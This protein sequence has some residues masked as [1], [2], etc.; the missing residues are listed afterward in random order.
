MLCGM[1]LL[2]IKFS[3]EIFRMKK[4]KLIRVVGEAFVFGLLFFW[5]PFL[6]QLFLTIVSSAF[7]ELLYGYRERKLLASSITKS[8]AVNIRKNIK[9]RG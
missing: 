5:L 4:Q 1:L 6:M 8:T 2:S 7:V 3:Y 9:N